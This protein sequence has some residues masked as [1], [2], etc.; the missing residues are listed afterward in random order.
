[1]ALR[2]LMGAMKRQLNSDLALTGRLAASSIILR[3]DG[4]SLAVIGD[5]GIKR[6]CRLN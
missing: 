6:Q 2:K 1:M 3:R 5:G 4:Q